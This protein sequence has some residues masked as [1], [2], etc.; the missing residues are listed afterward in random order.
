[1]RASWLG[2]AASA[3]CTLATFVIVSADERHLDYVHALQEAGFYDLAVQY[4]EALTSHPQLP[5]DVR[6][7]LDYEMG[8]SLLGLAGE[9]R[10]LT[11]RDQQL[12]LA[13][14]RLDAFVKAGAEDR[15][16]ADAL[17]ELARILIERGRVAVI[18]S[19]SP[20]KK[21]TRRD[22]QTTARGYFDSARTSFVEAEKKF[23][24]VHKQY[25]SYIDPTKSIVIGQR[26]VGGQ[27][28][29]DAREQSK[30]DW[31]EAQLHLALIEYEY[32]QTHDAGSLDFKARL[33]QAIKRFEE[34][35]TRFRDRGAGLNARMWMGKCYEE[36]GEFRKAVGFYEELEKHDPREQEGRAREL[37][38]SLQR[39][40]I[41]FHVICM[42]KRS[43][44]VLAVETCERWLRENSRERRSR[45]GLGV[46]MEL[47]AA[48]RELAKQAAEGSATREQHINKSL[49]L[50]TEVA[51]FESQ[52]KDLAN[53]ERAKW[54]SL[55]RRKPGKP[56]FE[57]AVA[58]AEQA[59]EQGK[60]AEAVENF[61][62]ALSQVTAKHEISQVNDTRVRLA[63]ALYK[64]EDYYGAAI[65]CEHIATRFPESGHA[66]NAAYIA[67]ASFANAYDKSK[68][69]FRST[70][71]AFL[72][73]AAKHLES[74]W[75]DTTEADFG[76]M[77]LGNITLARGEYVT[78]AAHF[79]R[80]GKTSEHFIDAQTRAG[81]SY[82]QA[83]L[84]GVQADDAA[85][86]VAV[87]RSHLQHAQQL[88]SSTRDE[89]LKKLEPN[90]P[91]AVDVVRADLFLSQI[92]L[93][94]AQP[95][96]ALGLTE[97]LLA[98][99]TARQDLADLRLPIRATSLR[100]YIAQNDLP[101]AE[102]VMAQ[103]EADGR[104]TAEITLLFQAMAARLKEE[105]DR[106]V[107]LGDR[108]GADRARQSFVAFLERL[109][110]RQAGQTFEGLNWVATAFYGLGAYDKAEATFRD[111]LTRFPEVAGDP[112]RK[113]EMTAVN[114][115]LATSLRMQRRFAAAHEIVAGTD[116]KGGI[117]KD[118]PRALDAR[119]E[120]G[121]ILSWWA[122]AE[123]ARW[124]AAIKHWRQLGGMMGY[125]KP[126]P[127][128]YHECWAY[129]GVARLGKSTGVP[130]SQK[131]E[132]QLLRS[133][134]EFI[135][136][137]SAEAELNRPLDESYN[138]VRD[139]AKKLGLNSTADTVG[140]L[141][142]ELVTKAGGTATVRN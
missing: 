76:R 87:L 22:L 125:V 28:A 58:R 42:N 70:E 45:L 133:E 104:D 93:E 103:I 78:A 83:Y 136:K 132:L 4:L 100:A 109:A 90:Q 110:A 17:T 130:S 19:N 1:M 92:Y 36:M 88:L 116:G 30:L 102:K 48:N 112:A 8:K 20:A 81:E 9:E 59:R 49:D 84:R 94:N 106:L 40:V 23:L 75:P 52:Y 33:E 124:D 134:L 14:T 128:T 122:A 35:Y 12:E 86:K 115:R 43:E 15:I 98:S 107:R 66:L 61:E 72:E 34:V 62:I 79:S 54:G 120:Q 73:E 44:F 37:L 63:F 47:A 74:K 127:T 126:K 68:P 139:L 118:N 32:A 41:F 119:M 2:I 57:D 29:V 141:F 18:Q 25:P 101:N 5:A 31:I 105:L 89:R 10:D 65:L 117:L 96:Q 137:T 50:W 135:T 91:I 7:V 38:E 67:V 142:R 24:A 53:Q 46:Q 64:L 13:R 55:G 6:G 21:A 3:C 26:K 80:V 51:R 11:R 138:D 60:W 82:W 131:A 71:L 99:L 140:K 113:R 123:P 77:T 95:K 114:L 27:Q 129:L 85:A 111:M 121:R 56:T 97:P 69:E 39:Q 16:T 108:A